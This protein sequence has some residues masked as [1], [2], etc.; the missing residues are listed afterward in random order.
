MHAFANRAWYVAEIIACACSNK[1]SNARVQL[2]ASPIS[3]LPEPP[4]PPQA[5]QVGRGSEAS[6]G[7]YLFR[8]TAA[9]ACFAVGAPKPPKPS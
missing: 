6:E 3:E 1:Q 8:E 7:A 9:G 4:K 2:L 5:R